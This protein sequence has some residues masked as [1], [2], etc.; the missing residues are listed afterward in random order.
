M[1]YYENIGWTSEQIF[2][3]MVKLTGMPRF[4]PGDPTGANTK[5]E[6]EKESETITAAGGDTTDT[7]ATDAER[8][9]ED[10]EEDTKEE[11]TEEKLTPEEEAAAEEGDTE[12]D[13][14]D[15]ERILDDPSNILAL[16]PS[17]GW[18]RTGET[19]V[20]TTS[21]ME[22]ARQLGFLKDKASPAGPQ[23]YYEPFLEQSP[24]FAPVPEMHP[25]VDIGALQGWEAG[26]TQTPVSQPISRQ[27]PV[28]FSSMDIEEMAAIDSILN[29]GN[30]PVKTFTPDRSRWNEEDERFFY[31]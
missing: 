23:E 10:S 30:P 12:G 7:T 13:E 5:T 27:L 26:A 21:A 6:V 2:K 16:D 3:R 18:E 17:T 28:P 19:P 8:F 1:N 31:N 25:S 4:D 15:A 11:K 22:V 29:G 24:Y 9:V 14:E 20:Q